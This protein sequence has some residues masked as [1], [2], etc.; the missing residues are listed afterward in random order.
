MMRDTADNTVVV[1]SIENVDPVGVHT[2]DSITVAPA[3]TL[4]D[5][6]YQNLRD[7][8]ID[9]IRRVGVDTGGCNI[10][11][12]VDP[13]NGRVIV[14]EMN[15][16]VS[17]SQRAGVEGDGLPDRQDRREARHRVPP[18]RDPERHH[19]GDPGLLRA[20]ARL[21]RRQGPAVRV[22]EV[23]G[24]RHHAHH[25]DEERRRGDGHRPQLRDR[26]CRSRSARSRSAG[27]AS[28]G[29]GEPGD[30]DALLA[31]SHDAR[32]TAASSPCSRPSVAG[33]TA[34]QVFEAT[35]IDPWFIDQIVLINE[36]ADE[37]AAA[38]EL[39]ADTA[40]AGRR[41]TASATPRSRQL[42]GLGRAAGPRAPRHASASA[43]SSRR[44]TPA[45]VSSP[46]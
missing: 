13:S 2:G 38:A 20:D 25:D 39:D 12:A 36:V 33:A 35:K 42:R 5:R 30:K 31:K 43:R 45:P 26:R 37:V 1:C 44:S 24:G 4:T 14:I 32:P 21:R 46:P 23:P 17:R 41:T 27:R 19:E 11:F 6:E 8:G 10:Q 3:L 9:I 18:R 7:I 34:E 29:Q 22:R 16:R 28:T 15:P 40:R